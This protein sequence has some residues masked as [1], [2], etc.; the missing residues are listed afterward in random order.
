ME[1]EEEGEREATLLPL[2]QLFNT[3]ANLKCQDGL[4]PGPASVF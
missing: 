4:A 1:E 3:L 2:V